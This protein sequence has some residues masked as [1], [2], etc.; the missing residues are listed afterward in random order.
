[1]S[2]Q[3][4]VNQNESFSDLYETAKKDIVGMGPFARVVCALVVIIIL[5]KMTPILDLVYVAIQVVVLPL[6]FLVAWGIVSKESYQFFIGWLNDIIEWGRQRKATEQ[7][8]ID[9]TD[10]STEG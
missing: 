2:N 7:T 5:F 6:L 1:M 4:Q 3:T 9:T 8:S 10:T